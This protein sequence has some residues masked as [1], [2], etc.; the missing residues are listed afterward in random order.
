MDND[1][2]VDIFHAKRKAKEY[3]SDRPDVAGVGIGDGKV[4]VYLLNDEARRGIPD[5]FFGF[6]VEF[7]VTGK[8]EAYG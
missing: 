5:D 6:P 7:V 4:R 1:K 8:I 3:L 2:P